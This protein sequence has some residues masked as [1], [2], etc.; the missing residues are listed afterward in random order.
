MSRQAHIPV[1][2]DWGGVAE[3][4]PRQPALPGALGAGM[5]RL[6]GKRN[7]CDSCHLYPLPPGRI[8]PLLSIPLSPPFLGF[9]SW[10]L[11]TAYCPP[12]PTAPT[13][14][15]FLLLSQVSGRDFLLPTLRAF[16]FLFG[17]FYF[18]GLLF[19]VFHSP[20]S[21]ILFSVGPLGLCAPHLPDL[22]P[23]ACSYAPRRPCGATRGPNASATDCP[24][25][26]RCA[27]AGRSCPRSA[28]WARGSFSRSQRC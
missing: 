25:R 17:F 8:S 14:P 6:A 5:R 12:L 20:P 21:P 9:G 13:S 15:S 3:T 18:F 24:A 1:G 26:A 11:Y 19:A 7:P 27:P 10:N 23:S 16:A 22:F 4:E 28:R 2:K